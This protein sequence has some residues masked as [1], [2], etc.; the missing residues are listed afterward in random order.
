MKYVAPQAGQAGEGAA[1]GR[2][3]LMGSRAGEGCPVLS[4]AIGILTGRLLALHL[5]RPL[6]SVK[7]IEQLGR[8]PHSRAG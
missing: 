8:A 5:A 1:R 4:E 6:Q 7:L 2:V 3:E